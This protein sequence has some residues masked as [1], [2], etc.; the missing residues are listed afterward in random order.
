MRPVPGVAEA[1]DGVTLEA[2]LD[3]GL[4]DERLDHDVLDARF[5]EQG[6]GR[7]AESVLVCCGRES[8]GLCVMGRDPV[9]LSDQG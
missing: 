9:H 4:A 6:G 7:V 3:V 5:Q 1:V 2:E 8:D